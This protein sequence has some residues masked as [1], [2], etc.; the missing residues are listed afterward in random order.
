MLWPAAQELLASGQPL[1]SWSGPVIDELAQTSIE[2]R[3]YEGETRADQL[4]RIMSVVC[5][6]SYELPYSLWRSTQS[7]LDDGLFP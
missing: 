1:P 5:G 4:R 7:D 6:R 2:G 3:P